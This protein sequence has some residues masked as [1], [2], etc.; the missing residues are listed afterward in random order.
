MSG[1]FKGWIGEKLTIFGLWLNL[2]ENTYRRFHD[3]IVPAA[4]GTTQID[5][6]LISRYGIFVVETKNFQGWIFGSEDQPNWTQ[7]IYG[8]KNS[9]QNPLKQNYRHKKCLAEYLNIKLELMH[10][11]VFFIGESSFKTQMPPNV[12][13]KGIVA[14]V[15]GFQEILLSEPELDR[16][17]HSI[18]Q[19]KDD[20]SLN[21]SNHMAS[22]EDRHTSTTKCPKCG[23]ALTERVAKKGP[24]AG[25][26]FLG[27][28]AFPKCRY[29]AKS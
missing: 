4:N 16:I 23:A 6:L 19:L 3:V 12:L 1:M 25:S 14:Y 5:H 18:Q 27:C 9:F 21:H 11:V 26:K 13:D 10:S 7:S 20:P 2:D 28:S 22:L 24:N 29:T 8:K 15:E 17:V